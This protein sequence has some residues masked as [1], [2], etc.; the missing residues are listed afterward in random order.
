MSGRL[1]DAFFGGIYKNGYGHNSYFKGKLI[2]S[3]ETYLN[4]NI[5]SS[6]L[7]ANSNDKLLKYKFEY[8]KKLF[9]YGNGG[10]PSQILLRFMSSIFLRTISVKFLCSLKFSKDQ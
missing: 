4:F 6:L 3:L 5:L 1:A 8:I 2:R 7:I 9:N 10:F